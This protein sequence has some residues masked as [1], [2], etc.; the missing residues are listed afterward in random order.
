MINFNFWRRARGVHK[1]RQRIRRVMIG[2]LGEE[3]LSSMTG[4]ELKINRHLITMR[5][6][7][8]RNYSFTRPAF[9]RL[10][11]DCFF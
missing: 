2:Y 4:K 3:K 7:Q 8:H 5:T 1:F 10:F 11:P 6:N 9:V